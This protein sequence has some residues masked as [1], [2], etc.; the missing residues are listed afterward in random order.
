MENKQYLCDANQAVKF[1]GRRKLPDE[2]PS[3]THK[4]SVG[5]EEG[6]ITAG[7][8]EDG[9]PGEV[10]ITIAQQGSTLSGMTDAFATTI[11][12][13][14]QYGVPLP[15]LVRKFTRIRFE[16]AGFTNNPDIPQASS[17]IDY[18]FRWLE[19]KFLVEAA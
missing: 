10:F 1:N 18:V 2:R 17:I 19:R 15:D 12:M 4:F 16:P 11:S 9:T 5:G 14:L 6:Y 7:L 3:I 13:M 8:Y